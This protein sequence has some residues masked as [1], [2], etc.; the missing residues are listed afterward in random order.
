MRALIISQPKSGTYLCANLLQEFGLKFDGH[1][2]SEHHY[3]LY[4]L[5]NKYSSLTNKDK[6]TITEHI[7]KSISKLNDNYIAVSHFNYTKELELLFKDFKKIILTRSKDEISE[8]WNR[9][10][11]MRNTK[12]NI[13]TTTL[14]QQ[15]WLDYPNTFHLT[16]N[17]MIDKNINTLDNLQLFLFNNKLHNSHL[18]IKNALLKDS[19]TKSSIR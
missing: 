11:E 16:F 17:D 2:L 4:N 14:R 15:D 13:D 6:F 12:S 10:K 3:Q 9:F 7:S 8:S 5:A 1:H 19:L 18:C